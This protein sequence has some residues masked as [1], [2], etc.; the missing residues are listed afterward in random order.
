M[1]V[2]RQGYDMVKRDSINAGAP[3]E[4]RKKGTYIHTHVL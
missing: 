4:E 3:R 1:Y 2:R